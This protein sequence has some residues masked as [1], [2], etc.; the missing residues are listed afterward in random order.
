MANLLAEEQRERKAEEQ[1]VAWRK[2]K[3]D[4]EKKCEDTAKEVGSNKKI[5]T[6]TMVEP[7]TPVKP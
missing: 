6:I 7:P 1:Q 5:S 3:K 2:A 4:N